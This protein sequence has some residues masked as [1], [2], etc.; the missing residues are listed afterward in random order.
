MD[1]FGH[2][3]LAGGIATER[4]REKILAVNSFSTCLLFCISLSVDS[5]QMMHKVIIRIYFIFIVSFVPA[6]RC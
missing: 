6:Q 3:R 2:A 5:N 1:G 4:Q